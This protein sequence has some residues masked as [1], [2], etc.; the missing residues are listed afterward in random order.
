MHNGDE[1]RPGYGNNK[2]PGVPVR[3]D[4]LLYL[5][6]DRVYQ[7]QIYGIYP[8]IEGMLDVSKVAVILYRKAFLS[9]T[10]NFPTELVK[11][12]E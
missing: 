12:P 11:A 3:A 1:T 2:C 9:N 5:V 6:G 10:L 7:S 4:F 8:D